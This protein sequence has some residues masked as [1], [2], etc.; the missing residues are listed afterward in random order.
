MMTW[1]TSGTSLNGSKEVTAERMPDVDRTTSSLAGTIAE[2]RMV[3]RKL[4][5][6]TGNDS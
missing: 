1:G 5:L 2:M 3:R 6:G 4:P